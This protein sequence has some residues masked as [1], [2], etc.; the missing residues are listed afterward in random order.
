MSRNSVFYFAA[1][2]LFAIIILPVSASAEFLTRS[3]RMGDRNADVTI[4][5]TILNHDE[6]TRVAATGPG[7]PGNETSYFGNATRNAVIAFQ[8]LYNAD[9][10]TPLG[11]SH[12][13]GYVGRLTMNMLNA[14]SDFRRVTGSAAGTTTATS[15]P[16]VQAASSIFLPPTIT[17][18]STT[19]IQNGDTIT[20]IGSNFDPINN[21]VLLSVDLD[22]K[23]I[24][25]PSPTTNVLNVTL[26]S[27]ISDNLKQA[28]GGYSSDIQSK[29]L[30]KIRSKKASDPEKKGNWYVPATISV[31]TSA[32]TSNA[33]SIRFNFLKI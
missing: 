11:L 8:E 1:L 10:L 18:L 27:S 3:L 29:L 6:R 20:I 16:I 21:T 22:D 31:K 12:G 23:F 14:V 5:Q 28:I 33:I 24:N 2:L 32:G 26:R 13:T 7:S 9:V 17:S 15:A 25:I 4:L 19:T 30:E